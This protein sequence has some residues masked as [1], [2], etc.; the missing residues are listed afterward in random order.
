MRA[1]ILVMM[2]TA[3]A[4]ADPATELP[5][6]TAAH[7][8]IAPTATCVPRALKGTVALEVGDVEGTATLCAIGS[9]DK[10]PIGTLACWTIDRAKKVLVPVAPRLLPGQVV[11]AK[12]VNGCTHGLCLPKSAVT[13]KDGKVEIGIADTGNT[14][15]IFAEATTKNSDQDWDAY[16]FDRTTKKLVRSQKL[17]TGMTTKKLLSGDRL[18]TVQVPAGP[19]ASVAVISTVTGDM[20]K[21]NVATGADVYMGNVWL[22]APGELVVADA[23]FHE[24]KRLA[25]AGKS[26][27]LKKTKPSACLKKLQDDPG[28]DHKCSVDK[29][30]SPW[31]H[32]ALVATKTGYLAALGGT[33]DGEIVALTEKLVETKLFSAYCK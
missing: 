31:E 25:L 7:A 18:V 10:Q 2:A 17:A 11:E 6:M 5:D 21:D 27:T 23:G 3:R 1:T 13:P 28:G 12:L 16:V 30:V 29:E 14:A 32:G 26:R 15:T 8:V 22:V 24:V 4:A 33:R 19:A 9:G 20:D